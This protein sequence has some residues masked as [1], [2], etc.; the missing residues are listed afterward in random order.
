MSTLFETIRDYM[1][2]ICTIPQWKK[3]YLK[4]P[5]EVLTSVSQVQTQQE[6]LSLID[7]LVA[8]SSACIHVGRT[9]SDTSLVSVSNLKSTINYKEYNTDAKADVG[10][11]GIV[12]GK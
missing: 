5:N 1:L 7:L 9:E 8:M 6:N 10:C 12:M 2:R 4:F 11:F 3:Y